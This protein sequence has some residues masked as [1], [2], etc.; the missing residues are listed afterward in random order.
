MSPKYSLRVVQHGQMQLPLDL[1]V[2]AG[3]DAKALVLQAQSGMRFQLLEGLTQTAPTK[4][5]IARQGADLLLTLP[6][7]DPS[8]PDVVIKGYFNA[9]D[10]AVMG[11]SSTGEWR[12]YDNT[13]W[14]SSSLANG[15]SAAS[16][17]DGQAS[18]AS[19]STPPGDGWFEGEKGWLWVGAGT[20]AL[21]AGAAGTGGKSDAGEA[22]AFDK[23][24]AYA[25]RA[26][27]A[28]TPTLTDYDKAGIQRVDA[29]NLGAVNSALTATPL[30]MSVLEN[31]QKVVDSYGRILS[32]ANGSGPDA[33]PGVDPTADDYQNVGALLGSQQGNA[34]AL[35]LLNNAIKG[36]TSESCDSV[37]DLRAIVAA[38]SKV[39]TIAAGVAPASA[40]TTDDLLLMGLSQQQLDAVHAKDNLSAIVSAIGATSDDG[41]QVASVAQLQA[42]MA[43][44]DKILTEANGSTADA[45]VVSNPTAADF[46]AI[47]ANIGQAATS[48]TA[49]MMLNDAVGGVQRADI[50]TVGEINA[51]AATLDKLAAIVALPS[52]GTNAPTL[53]ATELSRLGLSG[54][55][56]TGANNQA[57][58]DLLSATVRDLETSDV[59]TLA[60]LQ[61]LV[62]LQVLRVWAKDSAVVKTA[63]LPT[64]EDY[65][66]VG[67]QR[68]DATDV[69]V[70]LS[71]A[72]VAALN[73]F[74]D[75]LSDAR[76]DT[77]SEAQQLGSALFRVLNEANGASLDGNTAINPTAADYVTLGVA[78]HAGS[79]TDALHAGAAKLLSD[80]VS[81]KNSA[82]V[83]TAA[84]LNA[85]ASAV[86][87]VMDVAAGAA[88]STLTLNDLSL[89]GITG[90]TAGNLAAVS[91]LI[92][93]SAD[94][95]SGVDT[96]AE[97]QALVNSAR[98]VSVAGKVDG[99][100]DSAGLNG[101]PVPADDRVASIEPTSIA[102][103]ELESM[104]SVFVQVMEL[105]A[106]N[107]VGGAMA[108][109]STTAAARAPGEP[110]LS[111]LEGSSPAANLAEVPSDSRP[112]DAH[113]QIAHSDNTGIAVEQLSQLQAFINATPVILS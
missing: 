112:A 31:I 105:A 33:T 90:G 6:E 35:S 47:G 20:V 80:A 12:V 97:L 51:V 42:L 79:A 40:L 82:Q 113:N 66:R 61:S 26:P 54:F 3:K 55:S 87:H 2:R 98:G 86:D 95:G 29:N 103:A 9:Q 59:D 57:V 72:D 34:N 28:A 60:E 108:G 74:A 93:A 43:A 4:L 56:S 76:I 68:L 48:S 1:H 96:L 84:E 18:A 100:A 53:S 37:T 45:D 49:L 39:M 50:D 104:R 91:N 21:V 13:G 44:Y 99:A 24:K 30:D 5:R 14:S 27:G 32:E 11:R 10:V 8:A 111:G 109:G 58:A 67:V 62:S 101:L 102:P 78:G 77:L 70:V 63:A 15:I 94:D 23:L 19:L 71:A 81:I 25:T 88:S 110:G 38:V 69:A 41:S 89:L 36:L 85:L 83:D 107:G 22:S 106:I 46:A 73:S 92:Q 75:N 16:M 65:A 64:A 7:G 17:A 52:G